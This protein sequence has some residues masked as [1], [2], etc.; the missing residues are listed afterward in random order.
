MKKT[1]VIYFSATGKTEKV[2]KEIASRLNCDIYQIKPKQPYTHEDLAWWNKQSR[3]SLEMKDKSCRP[4]IV[5]DGFDITGYERVLFGYPIWWDF[6]P[7]VVNTF[8]EKHDLGTGEIIVWATSSGSDFNKSLWELQKST[9][10][11]LQYGMLLNNKEDI[12]DFFS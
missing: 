12:D 4:E 8:L 9:H 6:A 1:L 7:R 10:S 3:C 11:I 2:A 5:E